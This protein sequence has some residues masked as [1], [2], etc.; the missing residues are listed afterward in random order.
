MQSASTLSLPSYL[1]ASSALSF[2]IQIL[3][4]ALHQEAL[5]PH[6]SLDVAW[7]VFIIVGSLNFNCFILLIIRNTQS[8]TLFLGQANIYFY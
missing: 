3:S 1:P 8:D 2:C 6:V 5:Y 4:Q 7:K